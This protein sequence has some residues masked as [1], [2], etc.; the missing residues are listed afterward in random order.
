ME[1]GSFLDGSLA[2]EIKFRE[3]KS[4]KKNFLKKKKKSRK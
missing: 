3:I 4:Q 1:R 2:V